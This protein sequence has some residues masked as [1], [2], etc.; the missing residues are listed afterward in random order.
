MSIKILFTGDFCPIGRA[1]EHLHKPNYGGY[2]DDILSVFKENDL[3][4]V[5]LEAPL[6]DYNQGITKSGPNIKASRDSIKYLKSLNVEL[7]CLANNHIMD[8]GSQGLKDTIQTCTKENIETIGAG[9]N[10]T[11]A[12]KGIIKNIKGK[13]IGFYNV[14]ENEFCTTPGKDAGANP[15]DLIENFHD[16]QNLKKSCDFLI[17]IAH[18]GREHYQLPTPNLQKRYRFYID[19]GANAVIGHHTHCYSGK[20]EYNKGIIF[21]SLG[22]FIFDYKKKYQKGL[23]TEGI[24]VKLILDNDLNIDYEIYPFFQGREA[25]P[26]LKLM[27]SQEKE[28]FNNRFES[29]NSIIGNQNLMHLEW[30][31]YIESQATSYK[32]LAMIHNKYIRYGLEKLGL[33]HLLHNPKEHQILL[34]NLFKCETHHEIMTNVLER[35]L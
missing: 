25:D 34:L 7:A 13:N 11:L 28:N 32:N 9:E 31:K 6:T 22:N 16:I 27:N 14:A 5:N 19:A 3:N 17:V 24:M 26:T 29:L 20:E 18:G 12:R 10:Y 15:V 33:S 4:I 2:I 35:E 8:Y 23:W 21:Y 1:A 30:T